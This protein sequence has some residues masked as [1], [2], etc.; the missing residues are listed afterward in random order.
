MEN[1]NNIVNGRNIKVRHVLKLL[2]R[3]IFG[4][5]I[6]Q[7]FFRVYLIIIF[8]GTILLFCEFTHVNTYWD[9][10]LPNLNTHQYTF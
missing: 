7:I 2:R 1:V 3:I 6:P 10:L 8:L 9:P 4:F 5:T